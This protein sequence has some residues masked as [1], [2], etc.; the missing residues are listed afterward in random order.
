M[1][2]KLFILFLLPLAALAADQVGIYTLY[3]EASLTSSAQKI[4][5]QQIASGTRDIQFKTASMWCS[6]ATT[7]TLSVNGT[8]ATATTAIP[9]PLFGVV[10]TVTGW[11]SSNVGSGTTIMKY[12]FPAG[13]S[14]IVIDLSDFKISRGAGT[15]AN[16]TLATT[17]IT[18]TCRMSIKWGEW[19]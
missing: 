18:A 1:L 12:D 9:T 8:A 13:G 17:S 2:R 5:V 14:S 10:S 7:F 11:T 3:Q 19:R 6:A 16:L 15:S 4:T